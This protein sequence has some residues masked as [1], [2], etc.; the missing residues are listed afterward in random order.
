MGKR[1]A[2][3]LLSALAWL[4]PAASTAQSPS[5]FYAG[6]SI[7]AFSVSADDVDGRSIATGVF[8]G[9]GLKPW[10]DLEGELVVPTG[11][12]TR[13]H[14]GVSVSFAP[15]GSSREEFDRL[16]VTTRFETRRH[17]ASS[18]SLLAVFHPV[19]PGRLVPA[20]IAGV[21]NHRVHERRTYTP[22]AVP[23]GVDPNH[24]S[25]R[26]REESSTRNLGGPTI[27][28][29]LAIAVSRH[30]VVVPDVRF[31]Y[32]SIGDEINNALRSSVRLL[33]RF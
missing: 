29:S 18:L 15:P 9:V 7:G 13:S 1:G 12:F 23:D 4:T 28:A 22:V 8:S 31:D 19:A 11:E 24:A 26:A 25:V 5:S 20:F 27:G 10:L 16:G 21:T 17:V 14:T 6:A 3:V 33:W 30:L 2:C 32:G